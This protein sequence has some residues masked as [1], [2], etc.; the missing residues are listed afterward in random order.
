MSNLMIILKY[1]YMYYIF[2]KNITLY[3]NF[4]YLFKKNINLIYFLEGYQSSNDIIKKG[5]QRSD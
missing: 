4:T 2:F 3:V 1:V 5:R